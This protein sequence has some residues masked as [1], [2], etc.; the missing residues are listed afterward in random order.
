V[1]RRLL[2]VLSAFT[3]WIR[4]AVLNASLPAE[5]SRDWIIQDSWEAKFAASSTNGQL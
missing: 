1:T 2:D 3:V 4:Q 5:L